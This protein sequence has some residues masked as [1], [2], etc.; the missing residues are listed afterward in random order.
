MLHNV[1]NAAF[2]GDCLLRPTF[3]TGETGTVDVRNLVTFDGVFAQLQ[4]PTFF[5]Q[6]KVNRE[7][8][9]ISWPN[10]ADLCPDVL[11]SEATGAPFPGTG[12]SITFR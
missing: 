4:G 6:V 3:S 8:G 10:G 7:F 9:T 2:L 12:R 1:V 11:Y 5:R